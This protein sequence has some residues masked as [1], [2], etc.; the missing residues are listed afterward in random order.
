[1]KTITS[2]NQRT[3]KPFSSFLEKG[4]AVF[5]LWTTMR[6]DRQKLLQKPGFIRQFTIIRTEAECLRHLTKS[7]SGRQK[8]L[9]LVE[10]SRWENFGGLFKRINRKKRRAVFILDQSMEATYLADKI[11]VLDEQGKVVDK[12]ESSLP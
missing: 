5:T 7:H 4:S 8:P 3:D 9:L 2:P 1:M 12:I 6:A 11:L 10:P